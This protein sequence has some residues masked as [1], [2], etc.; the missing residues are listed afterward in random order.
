MFGVHESYIY[1]ILQHYRE[2]GTLEPLPRGGGAVAKF[3][4]EHLPILT[5]LVE[6]FPDAILEELRELLVKR[7]RISVSI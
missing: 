2:Q 5:S 3:K 4:P 1:K 7:A 6:E